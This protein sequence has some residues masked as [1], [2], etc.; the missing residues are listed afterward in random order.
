MMSPEQYEHFIRLLREEIVKLEYA[1]ERL[2]N[3]TTIVSASAATGNIL[4]AAPRQMP[5]RARDG[6]FLPKRRTA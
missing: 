6:K 1:N 3:V 5:K 4:V 2:R